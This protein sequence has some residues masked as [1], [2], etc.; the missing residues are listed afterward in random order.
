[1]LEFKS[2]TNKTK[3][4]KLDSSIQLV[5]WAKSSAAATSKVGLEVFTNFIGNNSDVTIDISDKSGKKFDTVK[6]KIYGNMYQSEILVPEKAEDELYAEVKISKLSLIK[7]SGPLYLYPPVIISNVKWGKKTTYLGDKLKIQ[8]DIKGMAD[9]NDV[10]IQIWENNPLGAHEMVTGFSAVIKN[11]K[12]NT[13]WDFQYNG[14]IDEIIAQLDAGYDD[15]P[16]FFYKVI[17]AGTTAESDLI[18]M[19]WFLIE[20]IGEDG[21]PFPN[22]TFILELPDKSLRQGKLDKEGR[23]FCYDFEKEGNCKINF[24]EIDKDAWEEI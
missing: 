24:P 9:G 7:K 21:K 13:E 6:G 22:E 23:Y 3:Q 10:E 19:N 18:K 1:M 4:V 16:K 20:M 15:I 2:P 17:A 8:A 5:R 14:T 11:Q 12:I